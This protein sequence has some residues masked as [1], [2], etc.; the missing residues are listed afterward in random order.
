MKLI[1]SLDYEIFFGVQTGSVEQCLIEPTREL[2]KIVDKYNVLLSLFVDAGFL[3]KLN[4]ERKKHAVLEKDFQA[5]CEQLQLL[6]KQGHDIQLHI[7]PHW[8]DS[9]FD[10]EQWNIVSTRYRLHDYSYEEK[11]DIVSKYRNVLTDIIG[12]N[13]SIFAYRAGGWC[14]QP[15]AEI[16][17]CLRENGIW[18]DSTVFS[19]GLCQ[20]SGREFDFRNS[21]DKELWYFEENPLI[22]KSDGY[23][24][25]V[26]IS[27]YDISPSFFWLMAFYKFFGGGNHKV[28]SDGVPLKANKQYYLNKLK[29]HSYSVASID[30]YKASLLGKIYLQQKMKNKSF[31]NIMGHPKSLT[32]YSLNELNC[33]LCR[34]ENDLQSIT[35]QHFKTNHT[36]SL[37][38]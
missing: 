29:S 36:T 9:Y 7:H 27:S 23:F 38:N 15:F 25:E 34:H 6:K 32:A 35:F 1:I 2:L 3:Y 8:E 13:D 17:N 4:I 18:L 14:I 21:P 22:E 33:F 26:P 31:L 30:G 10:G 20:E 28:F 11:D 37:S 16:S 5:I 24:L 12:D 19:A